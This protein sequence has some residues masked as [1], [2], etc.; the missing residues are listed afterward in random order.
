MPLDPRAVAWLE[1]NRALGLPAYHETPPVEGREV[2]DEH[3]PALFGDADPVH[4][5]DDAEARGVPVRIYRPSGDELPALVY[6]HG[7]GW[8]LG[9]VDSHDRL[10]RTLAARSGC[11]LVS[12]DYRLAP[13]H[14]FPAAVDDAWA[15]T[16]WASERFSAVAIGGDSAGGHLSAVTALRARDEALGLALQV[17]VYPV[18]DY[19]FDTGSYREYGTG[20]NLT[21]QSMRWFWEHFVTD[22]AAAAD[23]RVSPLRAPQLSGVAPALVLTAECDPLCDEGEAYARRLGEAGVPVVL[24]RYDGQ[25]HGFFRMPAVFDRAQDAIDEVAGAVRVAL[26][27]SRTAQAEPLRP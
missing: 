26:D 3:A 25:V 4:S 19:A 17:L 8:V 27:P 21:E 23:P 12:V 24:S 22:G 11:T 7:G 18:T 13:E 9:S 14:P 16:V 6:L 10:C 2:V 15:A 5:V 1:Q 20:T